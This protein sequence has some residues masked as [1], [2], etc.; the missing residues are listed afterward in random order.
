MSEFEQYAPG[1]PGV[2]PRWTSSSKTGVGTAL[3]GAS[4]V[5][6]TISHGILNEVYYPREDQACIRDLG[7]IVTD[8]HDFLSEEKRHTSCEVHYL[9]DGVPA[10]RLTNTCNA[11]HYR[12]E[13]EIVT[14]P[15][16]DVLLQRVRFEAS[17][18]TPED[19]HLYALLAPHLANHGNGNTGWVGEYK[20]IPMLFA[21]RDGLALALGCSNPWG[22]RSVGFVG[23]SD[24]WQDL[25]QHKQLTWSYTRAENGN[26]ALTGEVNLNTPGNEFVLALGFGRTAAEAGNRVVASLSDDFDVL[27]TQYV[28]QWQAWQRSLLPLDRI[29]K[30]TS[31]SLYH[32]STSVLRT[33]EAKRLPGGIIASLSIPWGFAKGDDELGGY[34]LVWPRDLVE[35]ASAL[36]A[37][38]ALEDVSRILHYLWTTQEKDGHWPQNMWID[39]TAYWSGIQMDET[40][41]PILLVDLAARE[42]ALSKDSLLQFWPMVSKAAAFIV[43]NGPVTQ[44]DR[45]EEDPGYSPFTLAAEIAALLAAADL[46][47]MNNEHLAARY[48]R[49]TA[50]AWN[51]C[52][53]RWIY[54]RETEW[55]QRF[56]VEGYYVRI[57]PPDVAEAVSP[58]KGFVPIKNRPPGENGEPADHLVSTDALALVRFGLRAPNDPRVLNTLKVIDALL[59]EETQLGPAWHRYN[60]DGYGEHDDG[61]PFDGTGVGR[62]WPLLVGERAHYELAAGNG[63]IAESLLHSMEAFAND[64]GMIPEQLW[65]SHDIPQ[66]EL[67]FGRP[68]GSA[69]PLVWAHAE[70]IKLLRSLHE[71]RVFDTPPQTTE[72]YLIKGTKS[73]CVV[74]RFNLKIRTISAGKTLRVE[75]LKPAMIHWSSD[76]WRTTSD[77]RTRDTGLGVHIADLPTEG[78]APGRMVLFTLLWIE[79]NRWEGVDFSVEIV[80]DVNK[81]QTG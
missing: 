49:E 12:I 23:F 50:D 70:Y 46:A 35:A 22:K 58:S 18:G 13:K 72:R 55:T 4:H 3:G 43:Q 9:A 81:A 62:L 54:V 63:G 57:A 14:D 34:H 59:K 51:D 76:E 41:L 21:E 2:E 39:G 69:M 56:G 8:G 28:E 67:F 15:Q 47:E 66:R 7:L 52:I 25:V 31:K 75:T 17:Q 74:W 30:G 27:L 32:T 33:H 20:G 5:W 77:A 64:G 40:A 61:T 45:W 79:A 11:G 36:L 80:Q 10:F 1:W 71:G 16:R 29:K 37:A 68:S 53:D 60:G 38:G 78:L 65:D 19:Y 24:G 6:F 73:P 48:L 26:V 44:E 42:K